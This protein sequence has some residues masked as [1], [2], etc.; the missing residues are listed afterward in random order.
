MFVSRNWTCD[1]QVFDPG[2]LLHMRQIIFKKKFFNYHWIYNFN[3]ENKKGDKLEIYSL[4]EDKSKT[5]NRKD[6]YK[7]SLIITQK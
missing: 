1:L 4:E 7:K 5:A 2:R 6:N 3:D